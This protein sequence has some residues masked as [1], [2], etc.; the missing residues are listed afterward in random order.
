MGFRSPSTMCTTIHPRSLCS[1]STVTESGRSCDPV[2][3][4]D[5]PTPRLTN[6]HSGRVPMR[7]AG[8]VRGDLWSASALVALAV[9][10]CSAKSR[11]RSLSVVIP[12]PTLPRSVRAAIGRLVAE[13]M[14]TTAKGS[15]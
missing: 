13:R 1:T 8:L 11:A 6:R 15:E 10:P 12:L 5:Y 3:G 4:C 14:T 2:I 9:H 7:L